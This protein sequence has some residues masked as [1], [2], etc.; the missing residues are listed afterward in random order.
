MSTHSGPSPTATTSVVR[1]TVGQGKEMSQG[2]LDGPASDAALREY[3]DK[4]YNQVV[5][6]PSCENTP[7][8]GSRLK[9][10][11]YRSLRNN[12]T[13]RVS[14]RMTEALLVVKVSAA[15]GLWKSRS[16]KQRLSIKDAIYPSHG[17]ARKLIRSLLASAILISQR[18]PAC[19][20]M[21]KHMT[22]KKCIKDPV[23]IHHIKQRGGESTEDFVRRFKI[24]SRDVKGAT[25]I[26]RISGFMHGITNPELIKRLHDKIPKEVGHNTDEFMHLKRHIEALL[27]ARK[28]SHVIK[29]LKQNSGKDQPK[30]NKKGE[31]SN[32]DK[33]LAILMIQPWQ[34]VIGDEEHST[35]AWMNFML[36]RSSS[37]YNGIIR[38]LK[39]RKIKVV[40]STAHGMLK[41]LDAGGT[42]TLKSSK[43]IPIECAT[44]S[45]P[46]RKP[47]AV[48][49]V[50]EERIKVAINP[51]Y[52][53]QTI[54]IGSTL[55]EE[56]QNK[57]CDLLQQNLD[58]AF[59]S[60]NKGEV[61]AADRNQTI[62]EEVE[63]LI[64]VEVTTKEKWQ[65][66]MKR[67]QRSSQAKE[68]FATPRCLS[69]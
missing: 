51:E 44:V 28:L 5:A 29:E 58:D 68:Y 56:G 65:K 3:C 13:K 48:N 52:P 54:M 45:G 59:R 14:S 9:R 7:R 39:V 24:E 46:E 19:Q 34:R 50:V 57:L 30:T 55:T 26:M 43:I 16:K 12:I 69:V 1:N 10:S 37:P 42:L 31:A 8:E 32:K 15:E 2:N 47:L 23:E 6:D 11:K 18:G 62:Q 40:P 20:V 33:A 64:D 17:Y 35:S 60:G 67:R 61:K 27:K 25:E 36:V 38:R 53:E 4:Y 41:F 21:S 66:K 49:Q 22:K 63:K